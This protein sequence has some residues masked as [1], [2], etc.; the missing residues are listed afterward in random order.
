L[1]GGKYSAT[2]LRSKATA[3][4]TAYMNLIGKTV[5][6][7]L[8][9]LGIADAADTLE[10]DDEQEADMNNEEEDDSQ[11]P[12]KAKC[13]S[14]AFA[15]AFIDEEESDEKYEAPE[16]EESFQ[17]AAGETVVC[18][19][20]LCLRD[21]CSFDT[22]AAEA[23]AAVLQEAKCSSMSLDL[24]ID[25]RMNNV[26]EDEMIAALNGNSDFES[27][28]TDMVEPYL[29]ALEALRIARQQSLEAAKVAAARMRA[30][31]EMDAAW[32]GAPVGMGDNDDVKDYDDD[33][34]WDSDADYDDGEADM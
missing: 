8:E 19:V 33:D 26:L 29:E 17:S 1:G 9:D 23:L 12:S 30:E 21:C 28:L 32:G 13:G 25:V 11:D 6:K 20:E 14:L 18:K 3:T 5:Q 2:A 31:P 27:D 24:T 15:C 4:T 10:S 16:E 22:R 34:R 7:E